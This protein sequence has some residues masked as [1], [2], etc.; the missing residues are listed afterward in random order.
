M[1]KPPVPNVKPVSLFPYEV[2][3]DCW[4]PVH[5]DKV[6]QHND[7]EWLDPRVGGN[8]NNTPRECGCKFSIGDE[9]MNHIAVITE[10]R[11]SRAPWTP[12]QVATLKDR[13]KTPLHAYTC[14]AH[15]TVAMEPGW[16]GWV[17]A[18]P[19]C[20]YVQNWALKEDVESRWWE[21]IDIR[22]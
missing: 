6:C 9:E 12:E 8:P 19:G 11:K 5:P 4:H 18:V 22:P 13:Q 3:H 10:D 14:I 1:A 21:G 17:C 2:C 20:G 7:D 15:S 16:D